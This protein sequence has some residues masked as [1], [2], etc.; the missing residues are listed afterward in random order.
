MIVIGLLRFDWEVMRRMNLSC[1]N[2]VECAKMHNNWMHFTDTEFTAINQV[3][4]CNR[5]VLQRL[6]DGS[7][8]SRYR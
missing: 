1:K 3:L 8:I 2:S 7:C 6:Y 4:L 5:M